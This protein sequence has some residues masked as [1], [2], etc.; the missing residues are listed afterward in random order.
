MLLRTV[1]LHTDWQTFRTA[2]N[3]NMKH[4]QPP[5]C[6]NGI[7]VSKTIKTRS[8]QKLCVTTEMCELLPARDA[9]ASKEQKG[10]NCHEQ[11]EQLNYRTPT[12]ACDSALPDALINFYMQFDTLNTAYSK[13]NFPSS[14]RP[15]ALPEHSRFVSMP[16]PL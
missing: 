16:L 5:S 8:N 7:T 9:E 12:P 14:Q 4:V 15:G 10:P 2:A 1:F 3:D 13:K 6:N 11:S